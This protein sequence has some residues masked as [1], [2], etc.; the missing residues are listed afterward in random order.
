MPLPPLT[1]ERRSELAKQA[2]KY[3]ESAKV[4]ARGVRRDG[5]EQIKGWETKS[6]VSKDDAK[7]WSDDVQK[8]TDVTIKKVD[9][10]LVDKDKDIRTV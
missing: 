4:A 5:M 3:A 2:S 10:M 1:A 6:E 9:E 7:R 8:M